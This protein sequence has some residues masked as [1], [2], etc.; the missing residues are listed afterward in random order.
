MIQ[1]WFGRLWKRA[2][3]CQISARRTAGQGRKATQDHP[4]KQTTEVM[5]SSVWEYAYKTL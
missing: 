3:S 2:V 5:Q 4:H 1:K